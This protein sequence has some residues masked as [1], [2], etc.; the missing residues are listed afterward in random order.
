LQERVSKCKSFKGEDIERAEGS[1]VK[2]L[3]KMEQ[4]KKVERAEN[5]K[6]RK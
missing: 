1:K 5:S 2:R 3:A 4:S 6:V